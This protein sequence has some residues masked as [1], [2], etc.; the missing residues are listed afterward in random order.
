[1]LP[2]GLTVL[3]TYDLLHSLFIDNDKLQLALRYHYAASEDEHGLE[4]SRRYEQEV[5]SGGG[6]TYQAVY[7]GLNYHIFDHHLKL[8][9][10][11]QYFHMS[12]VNNGHAASHDPVNRH[13]DGWEMITGVRL[14]F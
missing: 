14:Y 10:G 9:A 6:D 3:P 13:V 7:L 12:G 5:A 4:F 2:I 8:M 1:M 11:A